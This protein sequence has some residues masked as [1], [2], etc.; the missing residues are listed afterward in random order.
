MRYMDVP[1]SNHVST[2]SWPAIISVLPTQVS[3][4]AGIAQNPHFPLV[5]SQNRAADLVK[6]K[7]ATTSSMSRKV[8]NWVSSK[9]GDLQLVKAGLVVGI[10]LL[11]IMLVTELS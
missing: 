5:E 4:H 6:G 1:F 10:P 9:T 11:W 7:L 8:L 2:S 3:V